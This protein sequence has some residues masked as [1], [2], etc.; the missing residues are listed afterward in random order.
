MNNEKH[1]IDVRI[2]VSSLEFAEPIAKSIN[3]IDFEEN[4]NIIIS[5]II[6]TFESEI[7]KNTTKGAD[8]IL[9][10]AYDQD[11]N[12]HLLF[13]ELKNDFNHIELFNF[14]NIEFD[15]SS[16]IEEEIKN[17]IIKAGLSYSLN[18]IETHSI[19]DKLQ[20]VTDK[21][22]ALLTSNDE[23]LQENHKLSKDNIYLKEEITRLQSNL[24]DIKSEFSNFKTKFND[25]HTKNMLEFFNITEL[26][27]ETFNEQLI[28][29]E[30][31]TIATNKFKPEDIIV[32]QGFIGANSKNIAIDWLKIIKT[33]LIFLEDSEE[34][35]KEEL[36]I[37]EPTQI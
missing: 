12:Y 4:Y 15:N 30:K 14:S 3:N 16:L 7:V 6:P 31:I 22:N 17:C 8:I 34:E 10:G 2:V 21:Y 25:I 1:K 9:I 18:I 23:T 35:L 27:M 20:D 28:N 5:S 13:N 36:N 19:K 24:D 26:W 32:G 11:N 29:E 33:A 37:T